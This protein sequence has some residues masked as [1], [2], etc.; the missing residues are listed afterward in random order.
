MIENYV[1][2][3]Q[4]QRTCRERDHLLSALR[5]FAE[6][7]LAA[8]GDDLRRDDAGNLLL[9]EVGLGAFADYLSSCEDGDGG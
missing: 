5:K 7:W 6:E 1:S 3:M 2:R 4:H 9:N 8:G